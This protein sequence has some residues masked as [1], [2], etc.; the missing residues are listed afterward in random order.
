M[1]QHLNDRRTELYARAA[2]DLLAD[3]RVTLPTL[4]ARGDAAALHFWFSNFEGLRAELAPQLE[5]AYEAW[6]TGAG[7]T[8]LRQAVQ[9][10]AVHWQ[11][12]CQQ[13]LDLHQVHGAAAQAQIR[14]L[15]EAPD[16][17]C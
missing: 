7:D 1:R 5:S 12:V 15:L 10:G 9:A 17:R 14:A 13:V 2:R 3:C 6:C 8:A 4:L 11:A 16:S